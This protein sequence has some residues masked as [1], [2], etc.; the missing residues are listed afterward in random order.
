MNMFLSWKIIF[1]MLAVAKPN[2]IGYVIKLENTEDNS[3]TVTPD[4]ILAR[5]NSRSVS[6]TPQNIFIQNLMSIQAPMLRDKNSWLR[7]F[8]SIHGTN[9]QKQRG[10][11]KYKKKKLLKPRE[12][13]M[14]Q[15]LLNPVQYDDLV[16]LGFIRD[17]SPVKI[18][19]TDY[20]ADNVLPKYYFFNP[21]RSQDSSEENSFINLR[22][23]NPKVATGKIYPR[24]FNLESSDDSESS[25]SQ[26][27]HSRNEYRKPKRFQII[28]N[29]NLGK[30]RQAKQ[31]RIVAMSSSEESDEASS[32]DE[33]P[34]AKKRPLPKLTKKKVKKHDMVTQKEFY[35]QAGRLI[36]PSSGDEFRRRL[37]MFLPKR[38]HWQ[39]EDIHNLGY[40]WFNGPQGRYPYYAL[41]P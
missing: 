4:T 16:Y 41:R 14:S 35:L 29:E 27:S 36:D 7:L 2:A 22:K 9:N 18:H 26:E 25:S 40:Y 8:G 23:S 33:L 30:K 39:E 6:E 15:L 1:T 20:A 13:H 38:Y 11:N 12:L 32:S 28:E 3:Q 37:P 5:F 17:S 10:F 34:V 19:S 21:K 31:K 24:N